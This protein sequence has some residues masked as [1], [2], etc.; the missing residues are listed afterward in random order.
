MTKTKQTKHG[1]NSSRPTGMATA[2]FGDEGGDS[3]FEDIT[4]EDWPDLDKPPQAAEEGEA[5]KSAGKTGEG[6]K[7]VGKLT[8]A[9]AEG[10]AEAPPDVAQAPTVNP[11]QPQPST[12]KGDTQ[13]P[14]NDPQEPT[15]NPEEENEPGLVEYVKS[16][17]QAPKV[18][19]DMVQASKDQ[20]YITIYDTLL[21][22]GDPHISKLRNS[23]RKT[24]LDCIVHKSGKYLSEDDF[25]VYVAREDVEIKKK[26]VAVSNEAKV[27]IKEYYKAAQDLCEA[28]TAFIKSTQEMESKIDNK[29][30]FLD[31][32]RQVQLPAVQMMIRTREE[33][34]TLEGKTYWELTLS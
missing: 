31:I 25:A 4:E 19:F 7:A 2:R 21:Q 5:S 28:Q 14:T 17:W 33:E 13:D 32:I 24:V 1:G 29:E 11:P 34:E 30:I 15:E 16:Y 23:D 10:G 22:I 27:A 3:Q 26:Q 18:W 6:S 8:P 20:A 12:S 9:G